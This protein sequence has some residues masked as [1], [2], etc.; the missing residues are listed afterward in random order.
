MTQ[1]QIRQIHP[2]RPPIHH[3]KALHQ[4]APTP[5]ALETL[6]NQCGITSKPGRDQKLA[7]LLAEKLN[8]AGFTLDLIAR[9]GGERI[10]VDVYAEGRWCWSEVNVPPSFEIISTAHGHARSALSRMTLAARG[11]Q[12]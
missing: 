10:D 3:R 2:P 1:S 11:E 12:D 9:R 5:S 6:A 7:S 4:T 8:E